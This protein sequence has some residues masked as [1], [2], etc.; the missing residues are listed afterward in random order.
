MTCGGS[1]VYS[2]LVRS[3][4]DLCART[5][6]ADAVVQLSLVPSAV[7]E[8]SRALVPVA[9]A[10]AFD[11]DLR[12]AASWRAIASLLRGLFPGAPLARARAAVRPRA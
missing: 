3:H 4:N 8:R 6:A 5:G 9:R 2:D 10:I 12:G 11:D 7:G 1:Q